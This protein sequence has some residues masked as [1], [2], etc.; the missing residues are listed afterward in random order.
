MYTVYVS[1]IET[2]TVIIVDLCSNIIQS[3]NIYGPFRSVSLFVVLRAGKGK[4]ASIVNIP[5]SLNFD[6][7][8]S[9]LTSS[10]RRYFLA[11][12]LLEE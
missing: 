1:A 3:F 9:S 5:A 7:N 4:G 10:G 12:S 6:V 11:Y 2:S 8:I